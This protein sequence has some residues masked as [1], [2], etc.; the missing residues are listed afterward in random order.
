[1]KKTKIRIIILKAFA[2]V[3]FCSFAL[4]AIIF[5]IAIRLRVGNDYNLLIGSYV[6]TDTAG[7]TGR[8]GIILLVLIGVMFVMSVVVTYFLSNSIT[9]P[10]E[11]LS[12]FAH[13]IG[14][15]EFTTNSFEFEEE[16]LAEL[17]A[18][19]NKSVKQ[20]GIYDSEQKAFFQNVSHELRTP[21]M[22]IKCYAEGISFDIMDP[23]KASETILQETDR[24]SDLVTDLLYI[25][26]I[27]NITTVYATEKV[28]LP[29]LIRSC[30]S[31][32]QAMADKRDIKFVFI[33]AEGDILYH[34]VSELISRAVDNLI[35][36]AIRYANSQIILSCRKAGSNIEIKVADD[37]QGIPRENIPR[38]FE[39]FYKGA[40][41][42]NGIGLSIVKSIAEQ[43]N[44]Q[45]AAANS[46]NGGAVFT[47]TL[48]T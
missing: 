13:N 20:L 45:V 34:C 46:T 23:K 6:D 8:A 21:L 2:V 18:A 38:V 30:A 7:I 14:N 37:G 40:G 22:S 12:S 41:G 28:N 29:E 26:K 35:S 33:F 42:N 48:P 39:R 31:R 24:L 25:A 11:K 19:L 4:T 27:D 17:N 3:L 32:Q 16:E 1:M 36:N 15:G 47:I 44:G 43:H 9:K 10:I 5:N